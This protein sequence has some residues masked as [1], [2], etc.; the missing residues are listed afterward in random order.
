MDLKFLLLEK[1]HVLEKLSLEE[2]K[3]R[4]YDTKN[5]IMSS[6]V[7]TLLNNGINTVSELSK[8]LGISRQATHK[9]IGNLIDNKIVSMQ[10]HPTNKKIKIITLTPL[11]VETF[12][13]RKKLLQDIEDEISLKIGKEKLAIL[14][15]ILSLDWEKN[16]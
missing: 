9:A 8:T 6:R 11:G 7:A 4:G 12:Q 14:K 16:R 13:R 10:D 5:M 15:E 1:F 2:A 3:K